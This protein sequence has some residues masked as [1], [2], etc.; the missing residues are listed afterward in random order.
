M[1]PFQRERLEQLALEYIKGQEV[2]LQVM[3][4]AFA[5]AILELMH[6]AYKLGWQEGH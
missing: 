4:Q 2:D 5:P 1:T 3:V 6:E